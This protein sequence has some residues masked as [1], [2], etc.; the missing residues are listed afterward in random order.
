MKLKI[1]VGVAGIF[2]LVTLQGCSDDTLPADS[3]AANT[4]TPPSVETI[5]PV[6]VSEYTVDREYVGFIRSQERAQLGFELTGKVE[7]VLADVGDRVKQGQILIQLDTRLLKTQQAQLNAQ[8]QQISAQL[9]LI[10]TNLK[11]QLSLKKKGFSAEAEIDSLTSEKNV[12]LA[13]R[14]QLRASLDANKLQQTKSGLKAPF[15]GIVS[16]RNI[17]LGD[18][19]TTGNSVLTL[20]ADTQ[21]EA[22]IGV[23]AKFA[24]SI[25]HLP[26]W[27][28]RVDDQIFSAELLNPGANINQT[29]RTVE[30]RFQLPESVQPLDGQL[31]YLQYQDVKKSMGY[32]VPLSALTDGIR[33]TWNVFVVDGNNQIKREYVELVYANNDAAFVQSQFDTEAHIV[34]NGLH[35]VIPGQ[36]VSTISISNPATEQ[37][38][39]VSMSH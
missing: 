33:G 13:N 32:W 31:A 9:K 4:I 38:A 14:Q 5:Q 3:S 8:L 35:R 1:A 26:H 37:L 39:D 18:V 6:L 23:P 34:A 21:R 24:P 17:S 25:S 22:H 29:S 20:L 28:V 11:R 27:K 15:S 10:E 7:A 36:V 19:V 2:A 30:L 12:L 16:A